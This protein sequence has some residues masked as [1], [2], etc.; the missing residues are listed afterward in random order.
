MCVQLRE[1]KERLNERISDD[2]VTQIQFYAGQQELEGKKVQM[3]EL[4]GKVAEAN[5][6]FD[7]LRQSTS[8][9][10]PR[11]LCCTSPFTAREGEGLVGS[12]ICTDR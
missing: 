1:T 3:S 12:Y 9:Q 6:H 10:V 7:Q 4:E 8:H 11:H 5:R 2:E